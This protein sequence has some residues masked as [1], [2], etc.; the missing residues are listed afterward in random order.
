MAVL[1]Y[2]AGN[3]QHFLDGTQQLLLLITSV[4]SLAL[5]IFSA[6]GIIQCLVFGIAWKSREHWLKIILFVV[7][8][9][10]SVAVFILSRVIIMLSEGI[11]L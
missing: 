3:F 10:V 1:L 6:A 5:I 11:N 9:V 7:S 4:V 8:E 2:V